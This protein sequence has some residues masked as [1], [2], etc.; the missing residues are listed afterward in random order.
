MNIKHK[1]IIT[2]GTSISLALAALTVSAQSTSP[3]P[4]TPGA[5]QTAHD[6]PRHGMKGGRHHGARAKGERHGLRQLMT[7]EERAAFRGKMQAAKT[8]QERQQIA[9]ANRAELQK[10]AA[11]KGITLPEHRGPQ[12]HSGRGG[13]GEGAG[14]GNTSPFPASSPSID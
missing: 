11:E 6:G 1:W 9:M 14:R 13:R 4:A 12:A 3:A 2:A 10:R 8:P 7:R 5:G